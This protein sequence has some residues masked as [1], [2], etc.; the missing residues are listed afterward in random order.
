MY[1]R[2]NRFAAHVHFRVCMNVNIYS[3]VTYIECLK[4]YLLNIYT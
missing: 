1:R 3:E 2:D 4:N